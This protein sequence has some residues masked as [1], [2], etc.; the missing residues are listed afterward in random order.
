[1]FDLARGEARLYVDGELVAAG[2]A[3][4]SPWHAEGPFYIGA[5][6]DPGGVPYQ[7]VHGSVDE[8]A[9]WSSTLD[10]DRIASLGRPVLGG[11]GC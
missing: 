3:V 9:V 11:G 6:G 10:P 1:V 7:P 8:V 2:D 5:G 4:E